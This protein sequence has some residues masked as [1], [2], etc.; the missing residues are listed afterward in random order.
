M[1]GVREMMVR[2]CKHVQHI[3][4]AC[5]YFIEIKII[6]LHIR[7]HT[8]IYIFHLSDRAR[9]QSYVCHNNC[10]LLRKSAAGDFNS[11]TIDIILLGVSAKERRGRRWFN[12]FGLKFDRVKK[13]LEPWP[14]SAVRS[15]VECVDD[16]VSLTA[17]H[18]RNSSKLF[19]GY[20]LV[21]RPQRFRRSSVRF[22]AR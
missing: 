16:R 14:Y 8:R 18:R 15:K 10:L 21:G 11:V 13:E 2:K 7:Q 9:L 6:L 22:F 4:D 19:P 3:S 17:G 1:S 12:W 5:Y 20:K